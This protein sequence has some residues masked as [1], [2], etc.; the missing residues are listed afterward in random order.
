MRR[1][2]SAFWAA[3]VA[4]FLCFLGAS[5]ALAIDGH[6]PA[7]IQSIDELQTPQEIAQ[8]PALLSCRGTNLRI[9]APQTVV[10]FDLDEAID[11]NA[12]ILHTRLGLFDRLTLVVVDQKGDFTSRIY[13]ADDVVLASG[14]P[15]VMAELP[16]IDEN[17]RVV[18]ALFDSPGHDVTLLRAALY[19]SDPTVGPD[20]FALMLCFAI[21]LGTMMVPALFD[22][23]FWTALKK[24]FLLWHAAL[25]LSFAA[26]VFFRTGLAVELLDLTVVSWRACLVVA[27]GVAAHMAAMFTYSFVEEGKLHP[28]LRA[29]LP[30]MGLWAFSASVIHTL[31]LEILAPLG[32]AFHTFAFAPALGLFIVVMFDA[33][34][35]GS[36]AIR[37]QMVGWIPLVLAVSV[38]FLSSV[39][40][41]GIPTDALPL[42]YIGVL[43][44]TIATAVGVADRFMSIRRERDQAWVMANKMGDLSNKDPMTGLMNR[45]ALNERFEELQDKG[46]TTFAL[47]DLDEFKQVNDRFGHTVGDDVLNTVGSTLMSEPGRNTVAFRMGGEEF[48]LMLR[49]PSGLERAENLRTAI[50]RRVAS[51]VVGLERVVT[52][53]MGVVIS[54]P[55]AHV[56]MKLK[57]LYART[58]KLLYEAKAAGRNRTIHERITLFPERPSQTG[59]AS[60]AA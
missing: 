25:T 12:S 53:S 8:N 24:Q 21:I 10:R 38:Q 43:S 60:Q 18:F 59:E 55:E 30:W 32:G 7:C 15:M 58:D 47:L 41:I 42:F 48:L 29:A 33:F 13:K 20:H 4:V 17:S 45:R 28:K 44:E 37:F 49:G 22:I 31:N 14:E 50:S 46:F 51:E 39:L 36:R 19:D 57:D 34:R 6:S 40:P 54:P 2:I 23:A 1:G 9:S 52:A 5:P 35:R 26:L 3:S 11:R 16:K 27:L 56:P